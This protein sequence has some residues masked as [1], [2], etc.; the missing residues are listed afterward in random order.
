MEGLGQL[1]STYGESQPSSALDHMR[2]L[3]QCWS[4]LFRRLWLEDVPSDEFIGVELGQPFPAIL[5]LVGDFQ[6]VGSIAK[7]FRNSCRNTPDHQQEPSQQCAVVLPLQGPLCRCLISSSLSSSFSTIPYHQPPH[8]RSNTRFVS[9]RNP[10]HSQLLLIVCSP[11]VTISVLAASR[12]LL[13]LS[14]YVGIFTF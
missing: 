1:L 11:L 9:H 12:Y 4:M 3:V 7:L 8:S 5:R 10:D 2:V 14:W 13:V 6:M